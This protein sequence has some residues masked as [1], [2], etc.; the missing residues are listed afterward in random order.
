MTAASLFAFALLMFAAIVTPGPT[1]LL[2]LD[3]A[4]R[5]GMRRALFGILG[6]VLADAVLISLIGLGLDMVLS[7]SEVL[8]VGLKWLGAGWLAFM[9]IQMLKLS[10]KA[11]ENIVMEASPSDYAIFL[12]SFFMAISN[13][14]YYLFLA[15]VL[16][17]FIHTA[18]AAL[19]QY[20]AL[21]II[22]M[23]IDAAVMVGYAILGRKAVSVWKES[24][25]RW[26]SRISGGFLILLAGS[27]LLV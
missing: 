17:L 2:A 8:F 22:V 27:V 3:N 20:A 14:K 19:P 25:V 10:G 21:T 13:P 7:A 6:A 5:F 16:P 15:A 11:M 24:G 1:V 9:G 23:V 4:G 18:N 12:K 26:I